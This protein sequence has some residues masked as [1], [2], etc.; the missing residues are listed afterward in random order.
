MWRPYRVVWHTVA[1]EVTGAAVV[2]RVLV[3]RASEHATAVLLA[4]LR[5]RA[6]PS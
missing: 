4:A 3:P 2:L 1:A 5:P 6:R